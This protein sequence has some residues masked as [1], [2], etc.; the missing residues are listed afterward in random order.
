MLKHPSPGFCRL[1]ALCAC[2]IGHGGTRGQYLKRGSD[3]FLLA[4]ISSGYPRFHSFQS[5]GRTY[6]LNSPGSSLAYYTTF[7][8]MGLMRGKRA[9]PQHQDDREARLQIRFRDQYQQWRD[10]KIQPYMAG[11]LKLKFSVRLRFALDGTKGLT[12]HRPSRGPTSSQRPTMM[13][14]SWRQIRC[15]CSGYRNYRTLTP[16]T[17]P[18]PCNGRRL[19]GLRDS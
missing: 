19:S 12:S 17:D 5:R 18:W 16:S 15:R 3:V 2:N 1:P 9:L 4:A 10:P 6:P 7:H 11:L 13:T 14:F 8:S